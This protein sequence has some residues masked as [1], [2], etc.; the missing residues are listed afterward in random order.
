MRA[1]RDVPWMATLLTLIS[2]I[3]LCGLG[4]WQIQRHYWKADLLAN[5]D[6]EYKKDPLLSPLQSSDLFLVKKSDAHRGVVTGVFLYDK[7]ISI[8][9]RPRNNILGYE[10]YTPLI[11]ETGGTVLIHQGW[12]EASKKE[13]E[14][15]PE[16]KIKNQI[17]ITGMARLPSKPWNFGIHNIPEK[18]LWIY[19][20]IQE[21]AKIKD[22]PDLAPSVFH[23]EN[24]SP[25][26]PSLMIPKEKWH[27]NNNHLQYILFWFTMCGVLLLIY[28]QRFWKK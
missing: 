24:F 4:L 19:L 2:A 17:V 25:S 23:A 21:Y 7:E 6:R 13:L 22:I 8:G 26:M 1:H 15:R 3:I 20:D 14:M 11:L 5:L 18:E 27:P 12:V 28:Y 9:P 10:I 16:T